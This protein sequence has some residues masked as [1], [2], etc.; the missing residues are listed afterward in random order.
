ML[1]IVLY[2]FHTEKEALQGQLCLVCG[3]LASWRCQCCG[4]LG[5]FCSQCFINFHGEANMFHVGDEWKVQK[6]DFTVN[7]CDSGRVLQGRDEIDF[8]AIH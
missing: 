1:L 4:T 3:E 7:R 2:S 5:V 8:F 6:L